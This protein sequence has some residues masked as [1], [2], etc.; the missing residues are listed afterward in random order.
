MA[1]TEAREGLLFCEIPPAGPFKRSGGMME[2]IRRRRWLRRVRSFPNP[3]GPPV[4]SQ[5]STVGFLLP[6][7]GVLL[8]LVQPIQLCLLL[9]ACR[10]C[11]LF[12]FLPSLFFCALDGRELARF[13]PPLF[14]L[15]AKL[16]LP[17]FFHLGIQHL[18]LQRSLGGALGDELF[19]GIVCDSE[20]SPSKAASADA[21]K[22]LR[23][24]RATSSE[25]RRQHP[26]GG[27]ARVHWRGGGRSNSIEIREHPLPRAAIRCHAGSCTCIGS[28]T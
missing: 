28:G 7:N 25:L 27:L 13:P 15:L 20:A 24:P 9:L 1:T 23:C 26:A 22:T 3:G 11:F 14:L 12:L 5:G 21:S 10:P 16:A 19:S 2:M 6:P 8:L 18:L 4:L 17:D